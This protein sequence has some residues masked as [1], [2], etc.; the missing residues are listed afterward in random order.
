LRDVG[1]NVHGHDTFQGGA[2]QRDQNVDVHG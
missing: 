1:V 2:A